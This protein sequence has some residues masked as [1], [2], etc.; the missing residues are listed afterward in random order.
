MPRPDLKN[1]YPIAYVEWKDSVGWQGWQST[2]NVIKSAPEEEMDHISS[3][4]LVERTD[5]HITI[6]SSQSLGL[7]DEKVESPMK[8]PAGAITRLVILR[9]P[10]I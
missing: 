2:A 10:S 5:R 8:I 9:E 1:K 6:T 7:P 4:F 3:G